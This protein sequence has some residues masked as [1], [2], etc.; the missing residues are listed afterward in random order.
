M[1]LPRRSLR[2]PPAGEGPRREN[3]PRRPFRGDVWLM[4]LEPSDKLEAADTRPCLVV[5]PDELNAHLQTVLVAP[6][7]TAGKAYPFRIPCSFQK[8]R[9]YV[10]LDRISAADRSRL[11]S[12][13]GQLKPATLVEVLRSL[14][15]MFAL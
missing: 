8:T 10:M 5:S 3:G 14:Q 1:T 13:V 11:V 15:E 9:G 6:M 7:T 4:A 2:M 12:R